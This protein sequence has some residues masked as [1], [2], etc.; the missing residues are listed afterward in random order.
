MPPGRI[1]IHIATNSVQINREVARMNEQT[2]EDLFR[3]IEKG[4]AT[5]PIW[6]TNEPDANGAIVSTMRL[7]CG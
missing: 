4:V 5:M 7:I 2:N 6:V 3:L 1:S